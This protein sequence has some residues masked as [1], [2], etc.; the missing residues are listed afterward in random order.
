[1]MSRSLFVVVPVVDHYC[2]GKH[3]E[4]EMKLNFLLAVSVGFIG[5][6]DYDLLDKLVHYLRRYLRDTLVL[7]DNLQKEL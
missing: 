3:I 2:D 4:S 7:V 5:L 1:M 6:V